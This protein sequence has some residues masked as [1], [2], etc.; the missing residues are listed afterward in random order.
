MQAGQPLSWSD[1]CRVVQVLLEMVQDRSDRLERRMRKCLAFARVCSQ[2]PLDGMRGNALSE[3][4]QAVKQAVEADM[5]KSPADVPP[6][7]WLLGRVLFRNL[8]AIFARRDRATQEVRGLWNR[9]A[10]VRAGWR[11]VRGRGPVP[12]INE[13]LPEI[14]FEDVEQSSPMPVDGDQTLERYYVAKLSSL[15]FCGPPNFNL[16]FW[17]G[18]ESLTLTLPMILWLHRAFAGSAPEQALQHAVQLVDHHF[19][20][21]PMLNLPHFRY[22]QRTIAEHGQLEKLVAWYSR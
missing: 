3:S 9:L 20:V 19:G 16:P 4:L 13:F 12:R 8:L 1:V 18:F 2:L 15:Q 7:D 5:P 6:P 11:F 10:R 17:A 22:M 14:R 21:D